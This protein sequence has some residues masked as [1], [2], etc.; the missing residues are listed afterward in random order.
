V[1]LD[2]G[3]APLIFGSIARTRVSGEFLDER[4]VFSSSL[5]GAREQHAKLVE[6][7][8]VAQAALSV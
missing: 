6:E 2:E 8:G 3:D 4:E 5:E 7:L 1:W